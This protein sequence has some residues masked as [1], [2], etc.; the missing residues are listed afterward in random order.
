[1]ALGGEMHH[2]A[3]LVLLEQRQHLGLVADIAAHEGV[4]R[5]LLQRGQ[6]VQIAGVGQFV[7][8]DNRLIRLSQP[9]EDKVRTYE[10]STA[11]HK[12]HLVSRSKSQISRKHDFM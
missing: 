1:M 7:I 4:T 2:R 5:V 12:N 8:I 11:C 10:A 3:R 9:V 6:I